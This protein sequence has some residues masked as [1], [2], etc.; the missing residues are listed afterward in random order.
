MQRLRRQSSTC[1]SH[2]GTVE[3][4]K[5][6]VDKGAEFDRLGGTLNAPALTYAAEQNLEMVQFLV[7]EAGAKI[8]VSHPSRNPLFRALEERKIDIVQYLL[9]KE[10]IRT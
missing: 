2:F 4:A 1:C 7:E 3:L 9:G 6:L 10:L 8:D 5:F